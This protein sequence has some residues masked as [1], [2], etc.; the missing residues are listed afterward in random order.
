MALVGDQPLGGR[1]DARR[2]VDDDARDP[3]FAWRWSPA[4]ILLT[5]LLLLLIVPPA[6]YLLKT[7]LYTTNPDG[8]FGEFTLEFY[9][10]LIDSPRF[11]NRFINSGLFA[12]GAALL[13]IVL[14]ATLAW[15][16]ER[17]D[18]PLRQYAFVISII[19]LGIPHVL[20]TIAWLLVLGRRG[21]VNLFL[22]NVFGSD[23]PIINVNSLWGMVLVEGLIWTPLGFLLL[24]AVFRSSDTAFE[25]AALMSGASARTTFRRITLQLATP[26][27]LALLLLIFIRAFE[28]FDIPAL[29][30]S[31]GGVSVLTTAVF[32]SIRKEVPSNYGEAGAFSMVLMV[33]VA[34]LLYLHGRI[35]QRAERYQTITGKGFRPRMLRLGRWRYGASSILWLFF[36]VLLVVPLGII[37][38]ASLLPFYDGVSA[39]AFG[40]LT[41]DNY[42]LVA[43]SESFR[44]A[45]LNTL[46]MGAATATAVSLLTTGSAWLAVRRRAGGWLLD[47]LATLP[48]IFPAI[49][50]G[51]AFLQLFLN[52]P[53]SIYGTLSSLVLASTVQYLP[54]GMRFCYAGVIQIHRELEEASEMCG[55]GRMTT[56]WR[57]VA[58]LLAPALMTSWL[59][60]LLL[61]VR[62]VAM[63]VLLVGPRSQVVAV[64]LFD[65]WG[66][67]QITSLAAVGVVWTSLMMVAGVIFYLIVRRYGLSAR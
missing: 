56:F 60:V 59:F 2:I 24:S 51:V 49:V 52:L 66:N 38:L 13:A 41:L 19:S 61:S 32:D 11:L 10:D 25:E 35:L 58:P 43:G 20:Y 28:A 23:A 17:T 16:V 46:T 45:I 63:P 6:F 48:L 67:G 3:A 40:R 31:A 22:M 62:A 18:T 12:L 21:P 55:A 7:S 44:G 36:I 53:F 26:A 64:T 65:L 8:S 50:L 54:Y 57:I 15:I 5:T 42:R 47:Q 9:Q 4:V 1:P 37:V 39:D 30:G 29:V 33:V 14:G 34:V 27:L